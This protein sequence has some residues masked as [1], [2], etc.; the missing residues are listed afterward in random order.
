MHLDTTRGRSGPHPTPRAPW[1]SP[2]RVL[3]TVVLAAAVVAVPQAAH[4][5]VASD[6]VAGVLTA[7]SDAADSVAV[8]CV[9]GHALVNG[10]DPG[11]GAALCSS[12]TQIIRHRRTA[13]PTPS[14]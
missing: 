14:T 9:G 4:A 6:V 8:T 13:G 1:G 12:M 5:A 2:A 7:A 11:T 10:A 3:G